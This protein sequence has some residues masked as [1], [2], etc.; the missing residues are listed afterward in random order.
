MREVLMYT[1]GSCA[2]QTGPG[3]WAVLIKDGEEIIELSGNEVDTTSYRAELMAVVHGLEA[4][5]SPAHVIIYSDASYIVR[6]LHN[7]FY[8]L[9][10]NKW[11][12]EVNHL[13]KTLDL[14]KRLRHPMYKHRIKT[15][16]IQAHSGHLEYEWVDSVARLEMKKIERELNS[17]KGN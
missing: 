2:P 10:R 16:W 5:S 15:Q 17:A 7:W 12:T 1:N 11:K 6:G 4:I 14:W 8:N 3:G 9:K 13:Q